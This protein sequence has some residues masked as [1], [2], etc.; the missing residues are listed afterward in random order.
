MKFTKYQ[1]L[2]TLYTLYGALFGLFFPLLAYIIDLI[3][4]DYSFTINN[5]IRIHKENVLHFII[6]F[7]P[8]VLAFVANFLIRTLVKKEIKLKDKIKEQRD[9][10]LDQQREIIDD[11]Q[12]SKLI[13][14]AVLPSRQFMDK[15]LPPYFIL[16]MPKSIVSGD[17]YWV[18][19][20]NDSIIVD[21]NDGSR[22]Q[23]YCHYRYNKWF[24]F[25]SCRIEVYILDIQ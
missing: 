8:F 10:I 23:L 2:I 24:L 7:A 3:T 21:L 9:K 18:E 17:F 20:Y 15:V 14:D 13:Q 12:Y 22:E 1:K 11:I 19:E 25:A 6:D 16:S 4:N 5:V